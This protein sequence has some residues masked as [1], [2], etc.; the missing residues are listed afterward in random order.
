MKAWY[1]AG[2]AMWPPAEPNPDGYAKTAIRMEG[3]GV[4]VIIEAFDAQTDRSELRRVAESLRLT[5]NS[6]D[7][8]IWFDGPRRSH[9]GSTAAFGPMPVRSAEPVARASGHLLP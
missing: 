9:S 1:V 7:P 4:A 2:S 6:H 8:N 3:D 5:K